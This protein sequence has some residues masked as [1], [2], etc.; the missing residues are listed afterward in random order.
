MSL[1]IFQLDSLHLS[2]PKEEIK[3]SVTSSAAFRLPPGI[4]TSLDRIDVASA[5]R[6]GTMWVGLDTAC[7]IDFQILFNGKPLDKVNR[8]QVL[9]SLGY[10]IRDA[11]V[12]EVF[13]VR[14]GC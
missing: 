8:I 1:K 13:L 9:E 11:G 7:R 4:L 6:S 12:S 3:L 5:L 10:H 2:Y 14:G